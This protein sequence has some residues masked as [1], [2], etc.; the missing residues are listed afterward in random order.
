MQQGRLTASGHQEKR[1]SMQILYPGFISEIRLHWFCDPLVEHEL[2]VNCILTWE[3][4]PC[5]WRAKQSSS[6]IYLNATFPLLT[7]NINGGLT[8]KIISL[9]TQCAHL[10]PFS[11]QGVA[12]VAFTG[13]RPKGSCSG[14]DVASSWAWAE[15]GGE[16]VTVNLSLANN[17]RCWRSFEQ[18][19]QR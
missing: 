7:R 2:N 4:W 11:D 19:I 6:R 15:R 5:Y 10:N 1:I 16:Q 12:A 14:S 9:T 3:S 8:L 18:N 13:R 17:D